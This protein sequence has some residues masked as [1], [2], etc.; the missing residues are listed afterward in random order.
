MTVLV[1]GTFDGIHQGHEFFLKEASKMGDSLVVSVARDSYVRQYKGHPPQEGEKE[2]LRHIQA[3]PLVSKAFLGD[4]EEEIGYY[5][6]L[7]DLDPDLI[8][9]GH[10]QDDL[11]ESLLRWMQ[12]RRTIIPIHQLPP[13]RRERFS[14]SK[15]NH[16]QEI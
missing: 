15:L 16:Q 1:F 7:L 2:R 4:E 11:K 12:R 6:F 9:L 13:F 14:S 5:T 3:H 8:C 10:D